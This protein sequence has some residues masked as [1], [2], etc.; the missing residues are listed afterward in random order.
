LAEFIGQI[1]QV[2][3]KK[4]KIDFTESAEGGVL[5]ILILT[6]CFFKHPLQTL[7]DS[8]RPGTDEG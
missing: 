5:R 3:D 6:S 4:V 2:G 7:S 1:R 8:A